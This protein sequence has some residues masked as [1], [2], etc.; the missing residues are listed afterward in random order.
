MAVQLYTSD[1]IKAGIM[2]SMGYYFQLLAKFAV[3]V[4]LDKQL[5]GLQVDI[6]VHLDVD[7]LDLEVIEFNDCPFVEIM[8]RNIKQ[9]MNFQDRFMLL[10]A[11]SIDALYEHQ[12]GIDLAIDLANYFLVFPLE[13]LI[14]DIF[15][16]VDALY[17]NLIYMMHLLAYL[18]YYE[19]MDMDSEEFK[20]YWWYEIDEEV[21]H[22]KGSADKNISLIFTLIDQIEAGRVALAILWHQ[23]NENF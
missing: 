8:S 10:N 11:L 15:T 12:E 1:G 2:H 13:N 17:L 20:G 23:E 5:K 19:Q 6:P 18:L 22:F 14:N 9:I 7:E 3:R 16:D 4:R 21:F